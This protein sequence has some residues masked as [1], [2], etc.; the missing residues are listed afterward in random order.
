MTRL[1][2]LGWLSESSQPFD[3]TRLT[4]WPL[5]SLWRQFIKGHFWL[6]Q[7]IVPFETD[8]DQHKTI[9][10]L[11]EVTLT[12]R[13]NFNEGDILGVKSQQRDGPIL[14]G[15]T[16]AT[17]TVLKQS[18][19]YGQTLGCHMAGTSWC[20]ESNAVT[21]QGIPYITVTIE[22]GETS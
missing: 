2:F 13:V 4:S 20:S 9:N 18:G 8:L 6:V 19:G 3:I 10:Q 21:V 5:F 14:N 22:T 7:D 16:N 11:V 12:S 1:T 17:M 15:T